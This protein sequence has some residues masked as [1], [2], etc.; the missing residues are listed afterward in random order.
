[1][2][3]HLPGVL[4]TSNSVC[5]SLHVLETTAAGL[6]ICKHQ[7]S[8]RERKTNNKTMIS[9]REAKLI[10]RAVTGA[11]GRGCRPGA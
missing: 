6:I 4:W 2:S 11:G 3:E 1:M 7:M 9:Y 8:M 10:A 5:C